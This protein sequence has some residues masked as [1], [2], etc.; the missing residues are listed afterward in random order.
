MA[1]PVAPLAQLLGATA[2]ELA[3]A[4]PMLFGLPTEP[5]GRQYPCIDPCRSVE[6]VLFVRHSMAQDYDYTDLRPT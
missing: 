6:G 3:D 2:A 4:G 5:S 1:A